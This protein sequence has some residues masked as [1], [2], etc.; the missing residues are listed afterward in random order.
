MGNAVHI[1]PRR[2]S[3]V[4]VLI[5]AATSFHSAVIAQPA[6]SIQPRANETIAEKFNQAFFSNDPDFFRNR[7]L[8]RQL[9]FLFG[10]GSLIRNSFPENEIARD[11]AQVHNLYRT[12]LEQQVSSDPVIRTPDL[13]NPYGT[14]ILSSPALNVNNDMQGNEIIFERQ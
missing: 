6:L 14:S 11:A 2:L 5:V 7:S 3:G 12:T 4:L 9:N 1:N 8:G 13:P 10:A